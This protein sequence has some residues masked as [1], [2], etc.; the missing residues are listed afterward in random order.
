MSVFLKKCNFNCSIICFTFKWCFN[1]QPQILLIIALF[2]FYTRF[3]RYE[4]RLI[5]DWIFGSDLTFLLYV[6]RQYSCR[7]RQIWIAQWW[8]VSP[9]LKLIFLS[10]KYPQNGSYFPPKLAEGTWTTFT[11]N[12]Y[13]RYYFRMEWKLKR[14][15]YRC[16][17]DRSL[18]GEVTSQYSILI[19]I[20]NGLIW[21]ND[22]KHDFKSIISHH[23][24]TM[25]LGISVVTFPQMLFRITFIIVSNQQCRGRTSYRCMW[26]TN[27]YY[28]TLWSHVCAELN[29]LIM[30]DRWKY[31]LTNRLFANYNKIVVHWTT[32]TNVEILEKFRK[33]TV[34]YCNKK[35]I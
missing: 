15:R 33:L 22:T 31:F 12:R 7:K 35:W 28:L 34:L 2:D 21:Q 1:H 3:K 20:T 4:S 30:V 25:S 27:L 11:S 23:L 29:L 26:L 14:S 5:S 13:S 16:N 32:E 8:V 10:N 19:F 6:S 18:C 24:Q 17:Y 9:V